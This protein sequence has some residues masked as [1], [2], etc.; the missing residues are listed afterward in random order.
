MGEWST[1]EVWVRVLGLS[2]FETYPAEWIGGWLVWSFMDV[3]PTP[4]NSQGPFLWAKVCTGIKDL[5]GH[6]GLIDIALNKLLNP[7]LWL[8]IEYKRNTTKLFWEMLRCLP[9]LH[10]RERMLLCHGRHTLRPFPRLPAELASRTATSEA[11]PAMTT[12]LWRDQ[13]WKKFSRD[14]QEPPSILEGKYRSFYP[15]FFLKWT[16]WNHHTHNSIHA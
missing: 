7:K 5:V 12:C 15:T 14:E 8:S 9:F 2:K 6:L 13:I 4:P 3:N 16:Q 11:Q 10:V 1:M